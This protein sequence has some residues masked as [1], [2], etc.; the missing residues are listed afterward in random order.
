M[1]TTQ[2]VLGS[3]TYELRRYPHPGKY[4]G[5]LYIDEVVRDMTLD[6]NDETT[7]DAETVG[8]YGLIRGAIQTEECGQ[9]GCAHIVGFVG[10][11][12]N[13][14]HR[15]D[16]DESPFLSAI[17][18]AIVRED[19]QGFVSVQYFETAVALAEEWADITRAVD[20]VLQT[21]EE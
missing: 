4:E 20:A 5:G 2:Y 13:D 21:E 3:R 19:S 11:C 18:G 9:C 7:G 10:D 15:L 12:R 16:A 6:D 17:A 8:W 1:H 14:A